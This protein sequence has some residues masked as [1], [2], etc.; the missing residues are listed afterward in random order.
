MLAVRGVGLMTVVDE[1]P[2]ELE[3]NGGRGSGMEDARDVS[4]YMLGERAAGISRWRFAGF[5][6]PFFTCVGVASEAG[7]LDSIFSGGIGGRERCDWELK[8][9]LIRGNGIGIG[10]SIDLN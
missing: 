10:L 9:L 7:I 5:L 8:R 3:R 1:G 4:G 6:D 2:D